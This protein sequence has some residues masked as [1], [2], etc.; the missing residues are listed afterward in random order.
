[1]PL[2]LPTLDRLTYDELVSEAR[3]SL[4]ALAPGWTDYNAHDPGITLLELFAWLAEGASYRLDNIPEA[5]YRAFLRLAGVVQRPAQVAETML[6]FKL[7]A[8]ALALASGARVQS[9]NGEVVFQTTAALFVSDAKLQ[10]VVSGVG[11]TFEDLTARNTPALTTFLP[12]G[13]KPQPG[14]ALYLGFDMALAPAGSTV[15]LGIWTG[16]ALE[17]LATR[18]QLAAEQN[19]IK[20][21]A[22]RLCAGFPPNRTSWLK[23]TLIKSSIH[24][25]L[26][27]GLAVPIDCFGFNPIMVRQA[28]HE[29][30]KSAFPEHYSVHTVWEYYTGNGQWQA[31]QDVVDDT[32][33]LTLSG[34][35]RFT[36]PGN[37][38]S[39]GVT[40]PTYDSKYFIRCRLKC[41]AYDCPPRIAYVALNVVTARHAVDVAPQTFTSTG[42]AAQSF[43][44]DKKPVVPGSTMLTVTLHGAVDSGW[45]AVPTWDGIGPHYRACIL[46]AEAGTVMFGDGRIGRVPPAGAGINV[47]YQ[48]GGGM[49]G[50]VVAGTLLQLASAQTDVNV[51]QPFAACG[52]A[53]AETLNEAKTRAVRELATPTRAATLQD[54]EALAL[55]TPGVQLARVHAIAD[56]HPAMPCIPV[57]GSTTVVVLPPCPENKPQPT[58]AM[59]ATVQ[60]YLERRRVL[61]G[62]IHVVPPHYT[63]VAVSAR[64]YARPQVDCRALMR[65]ALDALRQFFHPLS[66]GPEGRGWPIGRA[67]YRAELLALLNDL[68]GVQYVEDLTWRVDGQEANRCANTNITV[69]RHG[70]VASGMHEITIN[71]GSACHE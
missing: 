28:H 51:E 52:G 40:P 15:S 34:T 61:T 71:E 55:A 56:Y 20:D 37:Q 26:V 43:E 21:E 14:D 46:D 35:V 31:L 53:V 49:G 41:G 60:R 66:G 64:L 17:D 57:S 44:L 39:G 62:E 9:L 47:G 7:V 22:N 29:R 27:E 30:I 33:A 23:E 63:T 42:R 65:Q 67:V 16:H 68:D 59:C 3:S 69:C 8:A 4:P 50:N 2:P 13:A 45:Q 1:M 25:E 58:A 10:A 5:S 6:V 18:A 32:R 36:V 48:T 38:A 11:T 24:P 19:A 54:F 12:F 70:L